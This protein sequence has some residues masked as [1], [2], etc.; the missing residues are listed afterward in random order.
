MNR[1]NLVAALL[2]LYLLGGWRANAETFL[3]RDPA[4]ISDP[5]AQH[6]LGLGC[7]YTPHKTGNVFFAIRGELSNRTAGRGVSWVLVWGIGDAPGN[8]ADFVGT[9]IGNLEE[10]PAAL[11]LMPFSA[12]ADVAGLTLGVPVWLDLALQN[13][14]NAGEAVVAQNLTCVTVEH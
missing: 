11:G 12:F 14:P 13:A 10:I 9:R 8:N 6:M 1:R 2:L 3:L 4:G 5:S 7:K